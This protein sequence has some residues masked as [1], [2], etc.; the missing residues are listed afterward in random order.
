M[1]IKKIIAS[2]ALVATIAVSAAMFAAFEAHVINVTAHIENALY[3]HPDEI[4]FGTVFPQE[5]VERQITIQMSESFGSE[6]R[7][8]DI[9]YVIKQK[10]KCECD[11]E[12]FLADGSRNP[13]FETYCIEGQYAA[14][15]YATHE[16]PTDYTVMESLC[17]YLSKVDADPDDDNDTSH[18]SYYNDPTPAEPNSGDE[19]CN[20]PVRE[21]GNVLA[22]SS[23]GWA[24]HS[25]PAGTH[26]VGGGVIGSTEPI[27]AQGIAEPG[28]TIGGET[29]PVFP[30]WT[31]TPP[32][33]GYVVENGSTP[34]SMQIYVDC[35]ATNPD[36]T[37]RLSKFED[38]RLDLWTIDLK[39]PPFDGY[40]GQDW[41]A[42][43]PVLPGDP[44]GEDF[45]CDLWIEV[46][47]IS[48]A[49]N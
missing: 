20:Q 7:V 17:P 45:G 29:Y 26:A 33:T 13:D 15:G 31:F 25:C 36:A 34:Q 3:V 8:D 41:P 47:E 12:E 4:A 43:C 11:Y 2:V 24:G 21:Y 14:V 40:V 16:C 22:Y 28:A 9:E 49:V 1:Y 27:A 5:Y 30:H 6:E 23:T 48:P 44:D 46:T 39:A 38:D 10:A 42:G 32:E 35:L 19:Y 18:P 37:G